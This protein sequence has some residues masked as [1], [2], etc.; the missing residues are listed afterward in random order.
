[1]A[2]LVTFFETIAPLNDWLFFVTA[3]PT[4]LGVTWYLWCRCIN[5]HRE[6]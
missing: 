1:M 5:D 3:A 4:V 6:E 2:E